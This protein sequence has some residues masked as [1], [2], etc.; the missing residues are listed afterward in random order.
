MIRNKKD[1]F[2]YMI[3]LYYIIAMKRNIVLVF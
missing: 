1:V 3:I 2:S